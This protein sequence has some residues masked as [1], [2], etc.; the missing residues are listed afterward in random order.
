MKEWVL[1][2][3]VKLVEPMTINIIVSKNIGINNKFLPL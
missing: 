3:K 1:R 2:N